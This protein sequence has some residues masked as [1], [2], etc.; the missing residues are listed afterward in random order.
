MALEIMT[1]EKRNATGMKK[2]AGTQRSVLLHE[3]PK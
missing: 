1:V 2:C 3:T